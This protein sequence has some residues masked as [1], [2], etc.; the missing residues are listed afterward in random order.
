MARGLLLAAVAL[1]MLVAAQASC[2]NQCSGH[3][4]CGTNDICTCYKQSG[5]VWGTRDGWTGADCSLRTCPTAVAF[6]TIST[7]EQR[8]FGYK[9][10]PAS[11]H[12]NTTSTFDSLNPETSLRVTVGHG[13]TF[14]DSQDRNFM[15]RVTVSEETTPEYLFE[16]K[17]DTDTMWS[18]EMTMTTEWWAGQDLGDTGVRVHWASLAGTEAGDLYE[19]SAVHNE[20]VDFYDRDDNTAHQNQECSGRGSCDRKTGSCTCDVGYGGE[21]CARTL[22]PSDCSGHG[23]CQSQSRFAVDAGTTYSNAWDADKHMGCKC[24]GG[25]RGLDCA[26][27]E[28]PSG[29]DPLG[30]DGGAEGRDCSGRGKCDYSSGVCNCFRGYF[31]ERCEYQTNFV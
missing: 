16:W 18:N 14:S 2:P 20:G 24:D 23:V 28:C 17:Y 12:S 27:R 29:A 8:V 13:S 26:M 11:T 31:G 30:A 3:G 5:T 21:A 15:V 19:F 4:V 9:F 25:F 10:T 1:T 6:D 7:Q 22:C